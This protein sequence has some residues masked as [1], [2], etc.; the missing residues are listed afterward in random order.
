MD[1]ITNEEFLL[2]L[3]KR[4]LCDSLKKITRAQVIGH[5]LRHGKLL[6]YILESEVE[7]KRARHKL[8]YFPQLI[9]CE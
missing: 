3:E 1:R 7:K 6:R 4:E 8:D 5:T 2:G 9:I